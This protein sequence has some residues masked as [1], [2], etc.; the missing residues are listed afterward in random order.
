MAPLACAIH[1]ALTPVLVAAMPAL[2]LSRTAELALFGASGFLATWATLSGTRVHR[3]A[4][5]AITVGAGLTSWGAQLLAAAPPAGEAGLAGA[6]AV[7]AVGLLWNA[8]LRHLAEERACAC[9]A[10]GHPEAG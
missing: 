7:T 2:A 10:C 8:R 9:P 4:R 1:C 6:A 5:P 3:D